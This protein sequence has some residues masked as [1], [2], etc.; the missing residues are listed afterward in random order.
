MDPQL[1]YIRGGILSDTNSEFVTKEK[2]SAI[3]ISSEKLVRSALRNVDKSIK[4][5]VTAKA[6]KECKK[7]GLTDVILIEDGQSVNI[8]STR[9]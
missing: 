7:L 3:L 8:G 9:V 1:Y 4:V 6:S 2:Y 5:I